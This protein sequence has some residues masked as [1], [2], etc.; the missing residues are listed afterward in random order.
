MILGEYLWKVEVCVCASLACLCVSEEGRRV[1]VACV[2]N[3]H[4]MFKAEV[5]DGGMEV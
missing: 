2:R 1:K 3:A 4:Q 5:C